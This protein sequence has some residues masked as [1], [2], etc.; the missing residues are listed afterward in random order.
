MEKKRILFVDDEEALL[1]MF[2][3]VLEQ[4]GGY[5]VAV[6]QNAKL[7]LQKARDFKPQI[8][9]IDIMMPEMEGSALAF[10]IRS[11]PALAQVPIVFL[12]GAVSA[13]EL[14]RTGGEIGGQFFLAKPVDI[15]QLMDCIEERLGPRGV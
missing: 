13:Q 3:R 8:I 5:E 7:A 9:F 4:K 12:T 6:E 1:R 15:K 10:E 14:A 2:K 11:D